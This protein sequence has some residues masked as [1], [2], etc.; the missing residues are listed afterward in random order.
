MLITPFK[1]AHHLSLKPKA[2]YPV[3]KGPPFA[4][5]TERSLLRSKGPTICP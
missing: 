2:H 1:G 4:P 3:Q 5:E